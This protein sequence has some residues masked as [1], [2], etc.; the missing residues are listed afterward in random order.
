MVTGLCKYPKNE[1]PNKVLIQSVACCKY[2]SC[3][4]EFKFE[5]KI[6]KDISKQGTVDEI[7]NKLKEVK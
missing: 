2:N 6:I 4:F 3:P 5:N 7:L 1:C